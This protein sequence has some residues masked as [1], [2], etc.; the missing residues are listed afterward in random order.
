MIPC[1]QSRKVNLKKG[2]ARLRTL[3][4]LIDDTGEAR[5]EYTYA[6]DHPPL[7]S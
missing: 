3:S 7:L 2:R 6:Q 5:V 4:F 1:P